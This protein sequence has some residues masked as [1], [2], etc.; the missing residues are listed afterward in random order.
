[1]KP[2]LLAPAGNWDCARAAVANGAN[3]VYFGLQQFNARQRADNF[4]DADLPALMRFLH[5]HNVRGYAAFNVLIFTHELPVA[6][7][8]LIALDAAGVDAVLVQ[9]LGLAVLAQKLGL[10]MEVHASTQMT[11]TSPEGVAFV[12]RLGIKRVVIARETSLRELAK[13]GESPVELETFVHGALC[14]CLLYTS[15]SPRDGL[16]SRM[17]S[18]A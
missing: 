2:E 15:P 3:A 18:S 10:R 8:Q 17:P 11:I 9:D 5:E 14:V 1:M 12:E 4:T 13:F 16:L 6:E 7:R